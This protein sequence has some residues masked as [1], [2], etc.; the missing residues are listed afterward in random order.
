VVYLE[1]EV[2][3]PGIRYKYHADYSRV[4]PRNCLYQYHQ[5]Q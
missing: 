2:L 3:V 1:E 5:Y 4:R